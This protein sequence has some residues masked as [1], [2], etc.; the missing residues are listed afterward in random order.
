MKKLALMG[1]LSVLAIGCGD[2]DAR[3]GTDSGLMLMDS[4]MI[5]LPDTGTMPMVDAGTSRWPAECREEL[6]ALSEFSESA[7]PRCAAST[8]TCIQGCGMDNECAF[9][10]QEADTTPPLMLEGQAVDCT[11]CVVYQQDVAQSQN[12]CAAEVGEWNCCVQA[13][14]C[15]DLACVSTNCGAEDTARDS[16]TAAIPASTYQMFVGN[17]FGS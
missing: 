16:C 14:N 1:I 17:C 2:D 6:P 8:I 13:N 4:G 5:V 11:T 12:G 15:M 10:C 3:G 7:F 9:D